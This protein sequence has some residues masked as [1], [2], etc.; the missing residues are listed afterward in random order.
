MPHS[1]YWLL[2]Q[3]RICIRK[4]FHHPGSFEEIKQTKFVKATMSQLNKTAYT[5]YI[6]R[7]LNIAHHTSST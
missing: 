5:Y 6:V 1:D 7:F 4:L 2:H 3:L